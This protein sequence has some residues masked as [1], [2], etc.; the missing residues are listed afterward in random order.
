MEINNFNLFLFWRKFMLLYVFLPYKNIGSGNKIY[1]KCYG[2]LFDKFSL[3]Y[4]SNS[5]LNNERIIKLRELYIAGESKDF[6]I[7][8]L[9]STQSLSSIF[10]GD[11]T[12]LEK[13]INSINKKGCYS[14]PIETMLRSSYSYNSIKTITYPTKYLNEFKY[15]LRCD[16]FRKEAFGHI[17]R[18]EYMEYYNNRLVRNFLEDIKPLFTYVNIANIKVTKVTENDINNQYDEVLNFFSQQIPSYQL[19]LKVAKY[20]RDISKK[21]PKLKMRSLTAS[22]SKK[23]MLNHFTSGEIALAKKMLTYTETPVDKPIC[24]KIRINNTRNINIF[25]KYKKGV[26][27]KEILGSK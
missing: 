21:S 27:L 2:D 13:L 1:E 26:K 25:L 22:N 9:N 10:L 16:K 4:P 7:M 12:D 11:Y 6:L 8:L 18:Y 23:Y 20:K 17:F 5:E 3:N 14:L 19:Y 15:I 24:E